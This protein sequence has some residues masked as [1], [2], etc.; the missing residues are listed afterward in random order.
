MYVSHVCQGKTSS[1]NFVWGL[2]TSNTQKKIIRYL[3]ENGYSS[4]TYNHR[5]HSLEIYK[6]KAI[7]S[8]FFC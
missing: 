2:F 8:S 4:G 7:K 5:R 6:I 3:G 1:W